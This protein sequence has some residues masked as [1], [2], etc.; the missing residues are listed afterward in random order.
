M[1]C[2]Q[3]FHMYPSLYHL[4]HTNRP[5]SYWDF[6]PYGV[7]VPCGYCLNCRV[8]KRNEWSDRCKYEYQQKLTAS[9]VTLT[10]NDIWIRD[11]SCVKTSLYDDKLVSS[12]NY[13][14]V[15]GFIARLRKFV[16][17]HKEF[18]GVLC[19]PDFSY[20]Y[21]GEYGE[22]G[23]VF[24]RCHFHVLFFGL[25][26]A[27]MR[28]FFANEWKFG[29]IEVLPVLDGGIDYVLKYLDKEVK[30]DQAKEK[31]DRHGISRPKRCSSVSFGT[32]LYRRD[33][34]DIIDNGFTYQSGKVRRPMPS[35]YVKKFYTNQT[36]FTDDDVYWKRKLSDIR[37]RDK[38]HAHRL[39]DFSAKSLRAFQKRQSAIKERKL[40]QMI[41]NTGV[42][43]MDYVS[44]SDLYY[45]PNRDKIRSLSVDIQRWLAD[46]FRS[47]LEVG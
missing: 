4:K 33:R 29:Y 45:S 28:K 2:C 9:F 31:Y 25:D 47:G 6:Y 26:F 41:L 37:L 30:G 12:L 34:Q 23:S 22:N 14:H 16:K 13:K 7:D 24:D 8:D 46:E 36:E 15:Q 38:A 11:T 32:G 39:T 1:A 3:P 19:N 40:R 43:V 5:W 35:Y 18:H 21:V 20:V 44:D 42:G 17:Y 27:F 10:Y